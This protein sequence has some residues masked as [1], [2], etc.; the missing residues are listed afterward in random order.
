M[1]GWELPPGIAPARSDS[2][3]RMRLSWSPGSDPPSDW[4]HSSLQ[5]PQ[6]HPRRDSRGVS[7]DITCKT[8]NFIGWAAATWLA[9]SLKRAE[10][11]QPKKGEHDCNMSGV[12]LH[13]RCNDPCSRLEVPVASSYLLYHSS[14]PVSLSLYR[15]T[16]SIFLAGDWTGT[17]WSL[18]NTRNFLSS[19]RRKKCLQ[20]A[21]TEYGMG[22]QLSNKRV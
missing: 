22:L 18:E 8:L 14:L 10:R 16:C 7:T 9:T 19:G 5:A 4:T 12:H 20:Q 17:H 13:V 3:T 2:S 1:A 11:I 21:A 15:R 6:R